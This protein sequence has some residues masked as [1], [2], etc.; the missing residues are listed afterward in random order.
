M[1]NI[2]SEIIS[3]LESLIKDKSEVTLEK[4]KI[5][6]KDIHGYSPH[7]RK[8]RETLYC[9]DYRTLTCTNSPTWNGKT[10]FH[11]TDVIEF[12]EKELEELNENYPSS[13]LIPIAKAEL[14]GLL[15]LF[16]IDTITIFN[17]EAKNIDDKSDS[18]TF[19][20]MRIRF[21]NTKYKYKI[22][23]IIKDYRTT[24]INILI[25][26]TFLELYGT[27]KKLKLIRR[28]L[29][30]SKLD[31][32]SLENDSFNTSIQFNINFY[33]EQFIDENYPYSTLRERFVEFLEEKYP[34]D[35]NSKENDKIPEI[36]ESSE[37]AVSSESGES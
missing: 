19:S 3:A 33:F 24:Q 17:C 4:I 8:I 5:K 20:K 23:N 32:Y 15:N 28:K 9:G 25:K 34:I 12:L 1:D 22:K 29:Y 31:W 26:T 11:K 6:F 21:Y 14:N 37:S 27:E 7:T 10:Y 13:D 16:N 30:T 2:A 18:H 35:K 36:N